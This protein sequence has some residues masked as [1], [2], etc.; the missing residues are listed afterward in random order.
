MIFKKVYLKINEYFIDKKFNKSA[1]DALNFLIRKFPELQD[2]ENLMKGSAQN[3][4]EQHSYY[5]TNISIGNSAASLEVSSFLDAFI[6]VKGSKRIVDLG[7]G[8]S[9]YVLRKYMSESVDVEVWSVDSDKNWLN[10]THDFLLKKN[11][12]AEHLCTWDEFVTSINGKFDL[13]F[14]DVRPV[15]RRVDNLKLLYDS[16]SKDGVLVI[17]DVHKDHLRLP[18]LRYFNHNPG[19]L[20]NLK[21]ITIDNLGRYSALVY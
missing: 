6:R 21:K 7:S 18:M 1:K 17:D 20:V 13:I 16:L 2:L 9:S 4:K 3:L 14:L 5:I 12:N 8:F 10:K 19:E 15:K 11:L